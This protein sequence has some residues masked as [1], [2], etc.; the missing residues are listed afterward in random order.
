MVAK[1]E[2]LNVAESLNERKE[3]DEDV[4][5]KSEE[6]NTAESLNERKEEE[7]HEDS[8]KHDKKVEEGVLENLSA[9]DKL[10]IISK[11]DM[12]DKKK[13]QKTTKAKK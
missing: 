13:S 1:S 8:D 12:I 9:F 6:L 5:A 2:E 10:E 11:M 4:V 3:E 7:E